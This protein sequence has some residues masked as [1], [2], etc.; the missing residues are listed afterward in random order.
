MEQHSRHDFPGVL[1]AAPSWVRAERQESSRPRPANYGQIHIVLCGL[2]QVSEAQIEAGVANSRVARWRIE[3]HKSI[4]ES[5]Q[6][7]A[8]AC[9]ERVRRILQERSS[10]QVLLQLVVADTARNALLVGLSGLLRTA[11]MES[12]R[13]TGQILL[14]APESNGQEL[15]AQLQAEQAVLP[16]HIVRYSRG[17]REVLR[18]QELQ[19]S[20]QPA[21][22]AFKDDGVY[23]ITGGLG[24]LGV[25][26]AREIFRKTSH[27]TVILTGRSALD[28]HKREILQ[29][30]CEQS[31]TVEYVELDVTDAQQ[32][33][34]IMQR[35]VAEKK[36]LNGII[37]AAGMNADNFIL[38]KTS[39]EF[40]GVLEPKV[41]GTVNLDEAS[42][43]IALDFLALFSSA[44]AV[45][46]NS[47]QADYA[48]AN[49]FMDQYAIYR[50]EQVARNEQLAAG[51][52]HGRTLSINWP[53]WREGGMSVDPQIAQLFAERSGILPLPTEAGMRAFYRTLT[54]PLAQILVLSGDVPKLRTAVLYPHA[55]S[56]SAWRAPEV[57]QKSED[58]IEEQLSALFSRS[59]IPA[60][61]PVPT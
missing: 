27:A 40:S 56:A 28:A 37:H 48:A 32:V 3:P 44:A 33:R 6:E 53:L 19:V 49:A 51:Q 24:G 47:G 26:F 54:L 46:G 35:I 13:L 43:E 7:L 31:G 38:K 21:E 11:T 58:E 12:S 60:F 17:S 57:A 29:S 2:E 41:A 15:L 16:E 4:A 30:L 25:L 1:Y 42:K 22:V 52:R 50:N 61:T 8:L 55:A 10:D 18:L 34:Q 45:M 59:P 14:T 39:E 36:Q 5:Y 20:E 9:F 23:L